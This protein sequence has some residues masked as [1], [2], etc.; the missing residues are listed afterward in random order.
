METIK[1]KPE[2]VLAIGADPAVYEVCRAWKKLSEKEPFDAGSCTIFAVQDYAG[3]NRG[4]TL[5][6]KVKELTS[7]TGADFHA[8]TEISLETYE[9]SIRKAGGIDLAVIGLGDNSSIGFNEP[10]TQYASE[11]HR[12]K[13]TAPTRQERAAEFSTPEEVPEYGITMGIKTI[14]GA[15]NICVIASGETKAKAVFQMLY[16]RDDS[17]VPSAFL[18][19]PMNVTVFADEA[20]ASKL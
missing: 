6:E 7:F 13:L 1:A 11:T 15:K 20:A 16:A 9:E 17:V 10:S 4:G 8:L 5:S 14:V 19:L 18:Q 3:E 2:C 12:Q